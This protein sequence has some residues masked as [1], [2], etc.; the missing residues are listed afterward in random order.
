MR[1]WGF[2]N[3]KSDPS[4]F[5]KEDKGSLLY[6]L[7]YV[8]DILVTGDNANQVHDIIEK[9]D[10]I[11]SLKILGYLHQFLGLEGTRNKDEIHLSQTKYFKDI[12]IKTRLEDS[13]SCKTPMCVA[14][15]LRKASGDYVHDLKLCRS[16]IGALQYATMTRP[17]IAYTVSKLSQFAESP[18][19]HH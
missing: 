18:S 14:K 16:V 12:L 7:I 3:T 8:D 5:V 17:D 10:I 11:C 13:K 4:L 19:T 9:M 2:Q 15:K 6:V 1:D